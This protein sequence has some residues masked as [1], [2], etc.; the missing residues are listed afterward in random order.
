MMRFRPYH[1]QIIGDL[2]LPLLGFFWWNW[3]LYFIVF[4]YLLDYLSTEITMYFKSGKISYHMFVNRDLQFTK[5]AISLA[6][7]CCALGLTFLAVKS[8]VPN[9]SLS[10]A[11]IRFLA[12]KDMGFAQGYI[13]IPLVGFIAYQRYK[14]NFIAGKIYETVSFNSIWNSHFRLHLLVIAGA[15]LAFG[16]SLI[17]HLPDWFYVIS[18]VFFSALLQLSVLK[19]REF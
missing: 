2:I 18:L 6:L 3:P 1:V 17:F 15:G 8:I 13:L 11:F 19:S 5:F 10:T 12:Y 9:I 16:L 14:M 7:L 4:F